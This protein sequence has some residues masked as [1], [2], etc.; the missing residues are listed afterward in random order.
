[1]SN[2]FY[3]KIWRDTQ[4]A[5]CDLITQ[6]PNPETQKPVK[7]R[8]AAFQFL[9]SFYI[10]YLQVFRNIERC[11]D[12][13][14][15][16]QK[17]RLLKQLLELVMGRFLEIK[18]E[19]M[20]L[21]LS[22]YHYFDDVLVDLK[23]TPNDVEIPIPKYFIYDN[24]RTLKDRENFLDQLL[25]P[26]EPDTQIDEVPMTVEQAIRLIQRH[27]RARQGRLRARF[28]R[29]IRQQED[30][31]KN[32]EEGHKAQTNDE[33]VTLL[34]TMWRGLTTRR[35]TKKMRQEELVWLGMVPSNL[36]HLI[37]KSNMVKLAQRVEAI[38]RVTQNIYEQEYQ[39]ALIKVREK[40]RDSEGPDMRET[41]QD[42]I[43]QWFVECRDATG[44]FPD[45]PD[46]DA[47]GSAAIFKEKTP[48][49]LER[50]LKEKEE[51]A[52]KEK[53]KKTGKPAAAPKK[54]DKKKKKDDEP[55]G[56]KMSQSVFLDELREGCHT[57][58]TVW[59]QRDEHDN[60]AQRHDEEIIKEE[61]R[62]EVEAE[63]RIQVDELLRQELRNLKIAI[64][65]E[66]VKRV[67]KKKG[68]KGKKGAKGKRG[69]KEKDLTPNRT[70]IS[71]YEELVLAGIIK[72]CK[73]TQLSE[74]YGEYSF[75][76]TTLRQAN[77]E[78]QPSLSD[79]RRLVAEYAILPLG[80]QVVHE[81]APYIKSILLAG[82]QG[83]GKRMLVHIICT[84][85]GANLFDLS[86]E[87]LVGKYP[88]KDGLKMLIHMVFKVAR[89]LQPSV[90]LINDCE[91][92]M[93]K[94]IPKTDLTD[95]KRLKKE[96]PKAMKLLRPEDRV[97]LVGCSS[98]PFE[99]EVKPLC[100]L[101]QKI[102]LIPR[103][104]Y[105]SRNLLWRALIVRF[106]GQLT[107]ALDITSLTKISDGY[108][109]GHIATACKQVLSDRR[110]AQLSRKRL[111]AS[112]F[113]SPLA[114]L[115]PVY[116]EEEEA[117]KAWYRKTPLGKQKALAMELEAEAAANPSGGKKGTKGGKKK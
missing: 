25:G 19:M 71:L 117:Y 78:P 77:I 107:Q 14:V 13:F 67:A 39:D 57:F 82:P 7:D 35:E 95:P 63:V 72:K 59:A 23:L 87:N 76:G 54:D 69:R 85:T 105:S 27:E 74:Y 91:K 11:Y 65:K 73:K 12:Q 75:L 90:I 99:A 109:A 50:E 43:R 48:E 18:H 24:F 70:L 8:V 112:E 10:K 4:N 104:D 68:R 93:K 64:D 55:E 116:A 32:S 114:T 31:D 30:A 79:V 66:K 58:D 37:Q 16:P 5:L 28:M 22:D 44:K 52:Q 115:D 94:K 110:I 83:V 88:G 15:H 92:M 113:V 41:M 102:I 53:E 9:A 29:E 80:S 2:I 56:W 61:K 106:G 46:E 111:V 51:T 60:F 98:A 33:A 100:S 26:T 84:E 103:P 96:L 36:H 86:A 6:E 1:M 34:Q 20:Q 101:Y 97:L 45:Y 3:N 49:E 47:G 108:T 21:E 40:I 62:A 42:Q 81:R 17:R 89:L 38:R